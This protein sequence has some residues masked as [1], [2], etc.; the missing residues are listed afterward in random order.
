M[1]KQVKRERF[2]I[3]NVPSVSLVFLV[4][5]TALTKRE[6]EN[7]RE[8]QNTNSNLSEQWQMTFPELQQQRVLLARSK[9]RT[10]VFFI[11]VLA[12]SSKFGG[13]YLSVICPIQ[14]VY[15]IITDNEVSKDNIKKAQELKVPLVIA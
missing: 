10:A 11:Y 9:A 5:N 4:E 1:K 3:K 6:E 8:I 7:K 14:D 13:G 12:D 15:K 2:I